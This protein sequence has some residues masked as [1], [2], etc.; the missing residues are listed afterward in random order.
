MGLP[1]VCGGQKGVIEPLEME[2]D[3]C[4]PP[5]GYWDSKPGPLEEKQLLLSFETS[6]QPQLVMFLNY[7]KKF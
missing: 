2:F 6:L 1:S 3:S 5:S 7:L 4:E